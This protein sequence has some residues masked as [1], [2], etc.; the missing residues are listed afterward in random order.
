V[1]LDGGRTAPDQKVAENAQ[2]AEN[3]GRCAW[4]ALFVDFP[5][6][7]HGLAGALHGDSAGSD[8]L[9]A[10]FVDRLVPV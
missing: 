10:F 6:T 1:L 8:A 9:Y 2:T 7:K 4:V 3:E 5:V